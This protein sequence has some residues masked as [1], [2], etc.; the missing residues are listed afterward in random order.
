MTGR[1]AALLRGLSPGDP[2]IEIGPSFA[3][4]AAKRDGWATTVVDHASRAELAAKYTGHPNVDPSRIEEVDHIWTG[5]PLDALLPPERHGRYAA[6]IASHVIEH[7]PDPVGFLASAAKL[8]D[9][10]RGVLSLAVPDKRWCFDLLKPLTTT[11]QV[12]AAHR[13]GTGRHGPATLF[14][15]TAYYATD[16]EGRPSWM[17]GEA[18]PTL[19]LGA[20]L[21]D[22]K[23]AFDG[24][25]DAPDAPYVD[26][27]A[28]HFTP[29]SFALLVLE[30][31]EVGVA[32]W[33]VDWIR[34]EPA[35]EF[36]VH[37]RRGRQRFASAEAREA[38]RLDLLKA[39]LLEVRAQTDWMVAPVPAPAAPPPSEPL[40]PRLEAIEARLRV[41]SESQLPE[42]ATTAAWARQAMR[43]AR[44]AWRQIMPLR[45]LVARLRG[46]ADATTLSMDRRTKLP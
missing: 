32:D 42:I 27:H 6:I 44:A 13:R 22:A 8:L 33:R 37:L 9:P 43:P 25:S 20:R 40:G 11:G 39:A 24:Y 1:N 14:D 17:A 18:L 34:P 12:L 36:L 2:I 31:G 19:R 15:H 4:V 21:E 29:S 7:I 45:R 3:P 23:S 46:R 30:L 10:E 16:A 38:A 35:V 26:C 41:I 28:W 5:G